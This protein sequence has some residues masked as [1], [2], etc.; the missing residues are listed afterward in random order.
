MRSV[1]LCSPVRD[2][3]GICMG[4]SIGRVSEECEVVFLCDRREWHIM[5]VSIGRV[6]E[7]CEVVFLCD[8]SE[9]H[10]YGCEHR[11]SM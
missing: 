3:S 11:E 5:G 8:R 10:I 6:C 4:V 1:R 2:V 7:E 9:W